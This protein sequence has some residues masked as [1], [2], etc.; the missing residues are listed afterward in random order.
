MPHQSDHHHQTNRLAHEVSPYLL[1]H[2]MN[3]V[4]WF[5]WGHE[6]FQKARDEDKPIFLS[7]GYATCHWCHVMERESFENE[8]IARYLNEHYISIKV[9]REERPDVDAIY[10]AALTQVLQQHG[11]WPMSIWLTPELHP[12]YGGTYFPPMDHNGR[13]GFLTVLEHLS[14]AWKE[15]RSEIDEGALRISKIV[16]QMGV[17]GGKGNLTP[18]IISRVLPAFEQIFDEEHGGYKHA[19][20]F[21]QPSIGLFL[22][23]LAARTG[24]TRPLRMVE[25]Q[26]DHM[27]AGG[28]Y[29]HLGGG[30]ARYSTDERWL[31]PHFEKMLY[32]NAQLLRLY[33]EAWALRKNELY[34]KVI[35]ETAGYVLRDM[36]DPLGGFYS[37]EDADSEGEEGKFYTWRLADIVQLL[38]EEDAHIFGRAYDVSVEGNWTDPHNPTPGINILHVL[39]T[40]E[41]IARSEKRDQSEIERILERGR[42]RLFD[43]RTKRARPLRDD[44]ILTSWNGL[45]ISGL[46]IAGRVLN[47]PLYVQ[48]SSRAADFILSHLYKDGRLLRCYRKGETR[49]DGVLDDY[50]FFIQCLLDLY[51]TT[52]DVKK[53]LAANEIMMTCR[54][55]FWDDAGGGFFFT[56]DGREDLIARQK[57]ILD[58]ALPA[59]MA[60]ATLDLVRLAWIR[61]DK[62]LRD[63]A[64]QSL[65]S[66][67]LILGDHPAACPSSLIALDHLLGPAREIVIA[68]DRETTET[69][70][71]IRLIQ[72]KFLPRT[73]IAFASPDLD[74]RF[75]PIIE[76]RLSTDGMPVVYVCEDSVCRA[77]MT[78]VVELSGLLDSYV[79]THEHKS[80]PSGES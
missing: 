13:A 15:R 66:I 79:S 51:E 59:A 75:A 22:L 76:N 11:G 42:A 46:A 77:P 54:S 36:T 56:P 48:A 17:F 33:S 9:D 61:E 64:R 44:K 27:A 43:A 3:P 5:P 10:M 67:A 4:D 14:R 74:P 24:D 63:L 6:A 80:S 71:L 23:R 52:F 16:E 30:F 28:I 32:D 25:L 69:N 12:F 39:E 40:P 2:A 62:G 70:R 26:L 1:Q 37:A 38:G 72:S 8:E 34:E 35:R 58:N 50:A 18:E 31:V 53:L 47:E 73:A 49:L 19:P 20:K 21:P 65:E 29:D 41:Q 78:D 55:L 45:M 68:G 7:I 60:V 57:D